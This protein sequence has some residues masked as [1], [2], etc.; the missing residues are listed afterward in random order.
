MKRSILPVIVSFRLTESE[1]KRIRTIAD[2]Y[3]ITASSV[4]RRFIRS[5]L[6]GSPD[7]LSRAMQFPRRST[8]RGGLDNA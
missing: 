5:T 3:G 4:L 1:V 6:H 8:N 2:R 7:A